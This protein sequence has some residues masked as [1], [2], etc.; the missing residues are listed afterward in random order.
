MKTNNETNTISKNNNKGVLTMNAMDTMDDELESM[1]NMTNQQV[2][3][4]EQSI[5][6]AEERK[7]AAFDSDKAT[8]VERRE[9]NK[10]K[11]LH[12]KPF[13]WRKLQLKWDKDCKVGAIMNTVLENLVV[14]IE[15]DESTINSFAFNEF[16]RKQ[17]STR[18]VD[19][20]GHVFDA[21]YVSN[22]MISAIRTYIEVNYKVSFSEKMI[23]PAIDLVG[24]YNKFNPVADYM[25]SAHEKWV[26]AGKPE[27][28]DD[29]FVDSLGVEK[30]ELTALKTRIFFAEMVTKGMHPEKSADFV[31]DLVGG[32][33]CG[34]T[35]T[36][37]RLGLE[38]Y[39]EDV[40]NFHDKDQI[41]KMCSALLV[42]DDEMKAT[43]ASGLEQ[44][45]SFITSVEQ[46]YRVPYGVK[47][48]TVSKNCVLSR[49]TNNAEYLND[50]TGDRRF[51]PM[52]CV[53]GNKTKDISEY[54]D[55]EIAMLFGEAFDL[56]KN[57][58]DYN[59]L[60]AEQSMMLED[61]REDFT[62]VS[63][64]QSVIDRY[65]DAFD[66]DFI[67]MGELMENAFGIKAGEIASGKLQ[68]KIS[69]VMTAKYEDWHKARRRIDGSQRRGW[70][71]VNK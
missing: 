26:N 50:I 59:K 55:D 23:A 68:S 12:Y 4:T 64:E 60:T 13:W 22:M 66:G 31:L 63:E 25:K 17:I 11:F 70:E 2:E 62:L 30:N 43:K 58:F 32:Q 69:S 37:R 6:E 29:F 61:S 53:K 1:M 28:L 51:M 54:T 49:T 20:R 19:L 8:P 16:T 39:V 10:M 71:R 34:K 45:K 42:N 67:T 40:P 36:L 7:L 47:A 21:G 24:Y 18:D 3:E 35:R 44:T 14:I 41:I 52:M 46:T 38:W 33:G 65:L 56:I 15:N 27:V 57:G 5:L 48:E 9:Y